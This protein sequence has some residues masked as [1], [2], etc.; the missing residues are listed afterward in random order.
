MGYRMIGTILS[1]DFFTAALNR[2][3]GQMN[4]KCPETPIRDHRII[5]F[6]NYARTGGAQF[7]LSEIQV[8]KIACCDTAMPTHNND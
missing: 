6:I 2:V 8:A 7:P 3:S 1:C 4:A 5:R